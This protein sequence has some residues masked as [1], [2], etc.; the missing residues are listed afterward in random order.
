[1]AIRFSNSAAASAAP[2]FIFTTAIPPPVAAA[3]QQSIA[4]LKES[5]AERIAHGLQ[6]DKTRQALLKQG[7]SDDVVAVAHHSGLSWRSRFVPG[8]VKV[9]TGEICYL[10]PTD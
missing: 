5:D 8:G 2:G 10:Y 3:A 6:V 7:N 9:L 4:H 1:L